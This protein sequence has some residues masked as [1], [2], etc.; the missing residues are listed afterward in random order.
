LEV[1]CA[2]CGAKIPLQ[3]DDAL[4]VCPYCSSTL[5]L[6]RAHTF[7]K[8]VLL[9][10]VSK[11]QADDLLKA[12]LSSREIPRP[13]IQRVEQLMLPFWGVR[14]ESLQETIPAFAPVPSALAGYRLPSAGAEVYSE[15]S[16]PDYQRVDCAESA[17][18][19]WEGRPDVSSFSQFLV[20]FFKVAYGAGG[21]SYTAWVEAVSGRVFLDQVPP[22]MTSA[23]TQKFWMVLA[24]MFLLFTVEGLLVPGL[25]L[26][27]LVIAITAA[28]LFP[29]V[30]GALLG[31]ER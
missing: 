19:S 13:P 10:N 15:D 4:L 29:F 26:S 30:K 11:V 24:L 1:G 2:N 14:G 16:A 12:D 27:A 3:R 8:F 6:D 31:L 23:I 25:G 5:Y 17:S 21:V 20:P 22:P 28:A 18:A 7:K 9:P